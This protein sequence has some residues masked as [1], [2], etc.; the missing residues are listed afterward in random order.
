MHTMSQNGYISAIWAADHLGP[1][2]TKIG[3]V[4]GAHDVIILCNF[5]FNIFKSFR[6]TEGQ[7]LHLPLSLLVI[8]TTVLPL[9]RSL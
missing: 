2:S 7:N 9:P 4:E 1:I 3:R 8:V 6:S 5:G